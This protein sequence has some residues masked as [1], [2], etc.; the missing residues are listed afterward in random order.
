MMKTNLEKYNYYF[1]LLYRGAQS[2]I[3]LK[4][5]NG[6]P[7]VFFGLQNY[8]EL[9]ECKVTSIKY[10]FG[11][12]R[13][14][15][16]NRNDVAKIKEMASNPLQFSDD[17]IY[18][19]YEYRC[20]YGFSKA[21][22]SMRLSEILT[23]DCYAFKAEDLDEKRRIN[24]ELYEP[25]EGYVKCSYCGKQ[26]QPDNTIYSKIIFQDSHNGRRFVNEATNPY[27]KDKPCSSYDQ[28]AHE[29]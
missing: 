5:P 24:Q 16:P 29:G 23:K 14:D 20:P 8:Y 2:Y 9:L 15:F 7:E 13:K 12:F 11:F 17:N 3:D 6:K 21:S 1:D 28:M 25:K 27:C 22:G 18:L 19:H 4:F 10:H 26:N